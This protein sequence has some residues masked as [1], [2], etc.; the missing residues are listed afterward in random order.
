M[1]CR[2]QLLQLLQPKTTLLLHLAHSCQ[3]KMLL[4][5][6]LLL[7]LQLMQAHLHQCQLKQVE[8]QGSKSGCCYTM[9]MR[10]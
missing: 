4:L 6:L 10:C 9:Q 2:L 5:L 8:A 7:L 3:Q 1:C